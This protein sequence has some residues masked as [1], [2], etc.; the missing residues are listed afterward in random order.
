[1]QQIERTYDATAEEVWEL[2]T[3]RDGIE[4]WWAPDGFEVKVETLDLRPGGELV[5]TM[6]ATGPEQVGFMQEAGLPLATRSR[7]TFTELDWPTRIAYTSLIDFVPGVEPYDHL[8]IVD[9]EDATG[10]VNVTMTVEPL[11]DEEWTYRLLAGRGNELD[12]LAK[13]LAAHRA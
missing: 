2:W 7:K 6:T 12:N 1:M 3:T 13:A 8:T 9:L 5:Y 11:H 10:G 4:S